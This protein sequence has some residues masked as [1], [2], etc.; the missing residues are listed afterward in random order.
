MRKLI[1]SEPDAKLDY[2][3]FFEPETLSPVSKI[4]RGSQIALAVF[5]TANAADLIMLL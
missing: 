3:E 1:E 5:I 4:S 2:V